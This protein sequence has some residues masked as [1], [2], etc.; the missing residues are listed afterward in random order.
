MSG[1][2]EPLLESY[3]SRGYAVANSILENW[4]DADDAYQNAL[5]KAWRNFHKLKDVSSFNSWLSQIVR[6]CSYDIIRYKMRR[7]TVSLNIMEDDDKEEYLEQYTPLVS[8]FGIDKTVSDRC[9]AELMIKLMDNLPRAQG[10]IVKCRYVV[11]LSVR[12]ASEALGIK[13]GTIKSESH[14]GLALLREWGEAY[15]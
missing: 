15:V 12:E 5:I 14:R 11:G 10:S 4:E 9:D 3:G 6:N 7:K 2:F 8:D 1:S 13:E